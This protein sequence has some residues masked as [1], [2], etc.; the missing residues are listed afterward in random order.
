MNTK[1]SLVLS[2]SGLLLASFIFP[3]L[4][5]AAPLVSV[6]DNVDVFFNG[7]SSLR[8]TSNLFRD[9]TDEVEDLVW[10]VSP[11]FEVNVGRGVSNADL[12]IITRY[13]FLRYH[14]HSEVDT[15]L[16]H[17]RAFGSYKTSRLDLNGS[18]SFDQNQATSGDVNARGIVIESDNI[19]AKLEGEYRVSPK[20]SFGS[21][22]R[23]SEVE[24]TSANVKDR[25]AGRDSITIP[26]DLFYE[27]TPK[28]DLI[29]G[30]SYTHTNVD[31]T[32]VPT[33]S[34]VSFMTPPAGN[35]QVYSAT[36]GY[37]TGSHY[38]NVGARGNLLPKLT[39][40]FRI[41]YRMRNSDDS[42]LQ[43]FARNEAISGISMTNR[44]DSGML[45]MDA[46]FTW[47]ASPKLTARLGLS[48]D[49]GV[50]GEG[51]ST[52][53]SS[54]DL[55]ASYSINPYWSALA[56]LGYTLREYQGAANRED[57]QYNC[58]VHFAY[59]PNQYW[60]FSGGYTFVE[61]DTN[62]ANRSYDSHSLDVSASLRY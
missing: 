48:R 47:A 26:V 41:G 32:L 3:S 14:D 5:Q 16:F 23:Y 49:F 13:D 56:N 59:T 54:V 33:G 12:S 1:K 62:A 20:F 43:F 55:S 10:S 34:F 36:G 53:N 25:L 2:S 37:E 52:E 8:W 28:V 57:N 35:Y 30:Y 46:D 18:A 17:V 44:S 60:R 38:F 11:G 51:G 9:E 50:G 19:A 7:S 21:G 31:G 22:V 29:L 42:T 61:N 4:S 27:L 15:E 6:G 24:F 40:F 39:G 45:G 58:G